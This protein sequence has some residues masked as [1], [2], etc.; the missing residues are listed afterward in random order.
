MATT[1]TNPNRLSQIILPAATASCAA[2][3]V[4]W[5]SYKTTKNGNNG[6]NNSTSSKNRTVITST[7]REQRPNGECIVV[8]GAGSIGSS[9][10]A[11]FLAQQNDKVVCVDPLVDEATL[12]ERIQKVWPTILARGLTQQ[13]TPPFGQLVFEQVMAQSLHRY[14][15][16]RLVQECTYENIE[17][18]QEILSELDHILS[19]NDDDLNIL[20]ATS[21]SFIPHELLVPKC[22]HN[23]DRVVIGHPTIPYLDCFMEIYG[24]TPTVVSRARQFYQA[25]GFD[26]VVLQ[27]TIP[28]H[29]F[30]SF[31]FL[32]MQHGRALVRDGVCTPQ[33]VNTVMRHLGREMYS[34]HMFL[35]LLSGIGGDRG[36]EGGMVLSERVKQ[37]VITIS[38]YALA[39]KCFMPHFIAHAFGTFMAQT[40]AA[41]VDV[42][43]PSFIQA[44]QE[45]ENKVTQNKTL[46]VQEGLFR[47]CSARYT[48]LPYEVGNDPFQIL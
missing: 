22:R 13:A 9:F 28:G 4:L 31:L 19:S 23:K 36:L 41:R 12:K 20:I 44:C 46:G 11:I 18:K 40:L 42:P 38:F 6:S 5:R 17:C 39:K 14:G 43:P 1:T 37:S 32:N 33:E 29:L 47:A 7:M 3:F 35:S 34:G 24:T 16:P 21:T 30:N 10:C 2:L 8:V 48:R 45:F 26:V 15:T 27:K 25:V